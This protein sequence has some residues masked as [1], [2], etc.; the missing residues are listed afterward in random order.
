V[1]TGIESFAL[2]RAVR[3]FGLAPESQVGFPKL[4]PTMMLN[5]ELSNGHS[6]ICLLQDEDKYVKLCWD[7]IA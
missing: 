1:T 6:H 2:K 5:N 4:N 3:V 7:E